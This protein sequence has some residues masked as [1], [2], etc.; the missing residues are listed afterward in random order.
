[1]FKTVLIAN[2]GEIAVRVIRACRELGVETVAV[3]SEADRASLHVQLADQAYC[4][5]PPPS[6]E[7]YL[8]VDNILDAAR[9]SGAEAI[10]PG[11]GFLA[12][13]AGFARRCTEAG[14]VFI[15]PR[16]EAIEAMGD[17]VAARELMKKAKVPC[18]PGSDGAV[19]DEDEV[20]AICAKVGF[21][22]MLKAAAGGGGK[23]MRMVQRAEDLRSSLRAV[24]SE[25]KS[26]FG[27]DRL[28]VEKFVTK[29]R[30]VEIQVMADTHG[31]VVYN[32]TARNFGPIMAM[33][34]RVSIV[35]VNSVV[36][37]GGIDPEVVVTPGIFVDR[38]VEVRE[39]VH[40]S[41]LVAAGAT[42]P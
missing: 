9:K 16:P 6:R 32:K 20:A 12:E 18:V 40:E 4:V 14:L 27:D 25:A 21:P 28:Y 26:S 8:V 36:A 7:S 5:G 19:A 33:A 1:M 39:P 10:H 41:D 35:Q 24:R 38:V 15:G 42:Y 31:N 11:Y 29:P 34:A 22:V 3:Y 23:G 37:P 2:R 30:H 17:K 13:N